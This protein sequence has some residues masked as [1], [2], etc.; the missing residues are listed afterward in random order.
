M[1]FLEVFVVVAV[2][3]ALAVYFLVLRKSPAVATQST[4]APRSSVTPSGSDPSSQ[5]TKVTEP[6]GAASTQ[7]V[8]LIETVLKPAPSVPTAT[9]APTP[10]V[11]T[12]RLPID[13]YAGKTVAQLEVL[14]AAQAIKV[15]EFDAEQEKKGFGG[16]TVT[17]DPHYVLAS[18]G[19][20]LSHAKHSPDGLSP[21]SGG[22]RAP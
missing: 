10:A 15:K 16:P 13:P 9:P 5:P 6:A 17:G 3:A 20:H 11:D 4:A 1:L 8:V 19:T 12:S 7:P 14:Y 18:I 2:V 22:Y 21:P